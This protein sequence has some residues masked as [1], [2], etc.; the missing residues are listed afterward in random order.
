MT[1]SEEDKLKAQTYL[2]NLKTNDARPILR[3]HRILPVAVDVSLLN[4]FAEMVIDAL[5]I[6]AEKLPAAAVI[7]ACGNGTPSD[8]VKNLLTVVAPGKEKAWIM[9]KCDSE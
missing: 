5:K 4:G 8:Q 2:S 6:A 9:E 3:A 1:G 7:K